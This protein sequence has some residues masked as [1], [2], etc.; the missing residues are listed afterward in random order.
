MTK[1]VDTKIAK[2]IISRPAEEWLYEMYL[3]YAHY[4]IRDRALVYSDGLKPVQ[5]KILYSMFKT[6]VTPNSEF[7]KAARV[8]AD[9]VAYHPHGNVSIEDSLARMAQKF[10]MR[11]PLIEP[12]GSVGKVA[13]DTPAAARYWEA[14]LSKEAMELLKEIK[15]G[16]A[17]MIGNF[18][19]KL[20]Q[21]KVLPVRWPVDVINGASGIAVGYACE[22]P[23]HNPDEVM[24]A[25]R[26][27]LKNPDM[28][29][30]QLMKIM[31]GPDFPSGG[32]IVGKEEIEKYFEEG[33]GT[34]KVRARY[35]VEP[36]TRGRTRIV[37]YELPYLVSPKS[38]ELKLK[39]AKSA[40]QLK[41]ISYF[42]DETDKKNG[43]RLVVE[44]KN[45]ANYVSVLNTLF[46]GSYGFQNSFSVNSTVLV[47]GSPQLVP[48]KELILDFLQLR[49]E[50]T[51]R[52]TENR[53]KKLEAKLK[54]M[55]AI[56][57]VI[58]DIDKTISIIR[59]AE[60]SE[61]AKEKLMKAFKIDEEQS[62]MILGI[63]L[64]RLTKADSLSIKNE[65]KELKEEIKELN[66]VLTSDEALNKIIDKELLETKKVISSERRTVITEMTLNQLKEDEKKI[67]KLAKELDKNGPCYLTRFAD[68]TLMKSE[69]PFVYP[70]KTKIFK[71]TPV[72]EQIK[73][74]TDDSFVAITSDGMG[75]RL[76]LSYLPMD[77]ATNPNT[78]GL[79]L[80]Q[81]RKFVGFAKTSTGENETGIG[82]GTKNGLV[83]IAKTDF[84]NKEEFP[85]ILLDE[86]DTLV[87]SAWISK[88]EKT[89]FVFIN[90][91]G[92]ILSFDAST[93]RV[94]GSK[95]GGVR[96]MKLRENDHVVS[97]NWVEDTKNALIL[98]QADLTVKL[99]SLSEIP[100]KNK[101]AMGVALHLFKKG[102]TSLNN[103]YVG[104]NP[105][106]SVTEMKNEVLLPPLTKRAT[107]GVNLKIE[108]NMGSKSL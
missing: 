102:E 80:T 61:I 104:I 13:G 50:L 47:D 18:D 53:I 66:N 24:E 28:T 11:V 4:V 32:E 105:I 55:T 10:T 96:G 86:T 101:G 17:E 12:H 2:Q 14:R 9:T 34:F 1:N 7:L 22:L 20:Q 54:E 84:P 60:T 3:P 30:K 77:V 78:L 39:R 65:T 72:V 33:N 108:T 85:V 103:A 73:M 38:I 92:T 40:G 29:V 97:F 94:S 83:K 56:L 93:I 31:P 23:P 106:M 88:V 45:G 43:L 26:K 74:N 16:A 51:L 95:A 58:V 21:P 107:R 75:K 15:D 63:Q 89:N 6:G 91:S 36:L 42:S 52:K 5:R 62:E 69:K 35:H 76:P 70:E 37:F 87:N 59:K 68:G 90:S 100:P 19:G 46:K 57:A 48:V 67:N 44:V 99:T 25:A 81:N 98:S 79:K 27:L 41:E 64:R 49:K 82:L 8:A 71:N